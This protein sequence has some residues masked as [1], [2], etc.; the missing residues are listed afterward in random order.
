[1]PR[2]KKPFISRTKHIDT[3]QEQNKLFS[4]F[5]FLLLRSLKL[6]ELHAVFGK[7]VEGRTFGHHHV[8]IRQMRESKANTKNIFLYIALKNYEK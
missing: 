4:L 3:K 1:M 8:N 2:E 6:E 7:V 5:C